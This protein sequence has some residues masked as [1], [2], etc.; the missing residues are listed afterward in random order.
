MHPLVYM[1]NL[2]LTAAVVGTAVAPLPDAGNELDLFVKQALDNRAAG[3]KI[4]EQYIFSEEEVLEIRESGSGEPVSRRKS[5][6]RWFA[7]ERGGLVRSPVIVDGATVGDESRIRYEDTWL[8]GGP[9]G[10]QRSDITEDGFF[11]FT[12]EPGR[13]L[14]SGKTVHQG[15]PCLIIEYYPLKHFAERGRDPITSRGDRYDPLFDRT[16]RILM[17]IDREDRQIVHVEFNNQSMEYLPLSWLAELEEFTAEMTMVRTAAG[18][19]LP[20]SQAVRTLINTPEIRLEIRLQRRFTDY[21]RQGIRIKFF[22]GDGG[23]QP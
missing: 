22:T 16:S 15:R 8:T 5:E 2:I 19:W 12:F 7:R 17:I 20:A 4:L 18:E 9:R 10:K 13:Y 11:N 21:R 1:I 3:W 6:W 14:L 23:E